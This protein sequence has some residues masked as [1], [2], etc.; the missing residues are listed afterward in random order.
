MAMVLLVSAG[1]TLRSFFGLL[2]VDS[3]FDPR[4]LV[5]MEVSVAGTSEA[6]PSKRPEFFRALLDRVRAI[7]GVEAASA[8]NHAP[9]VGDVWTFDFAV[10]S[11]GGRPLLRPDQRPNGVF[12]VVLPGYFQTMRIPLLKGRD[13]TD[14]DV[15]DAPHVVII[16]DFMARRHFPGDD[17]IGQRIAAGNLTTP[18][19]C[20]VVGVVRNAKR[21]NWSEPDAEE[22]YFPYLQ[23]RLY[24]ENPRSFATY[25]TLVARTSLNP[26]GLI[27]AADTLART[28]NHD[29]VVTNAITMERAIAGEFAAPRFYLLLLGVFAGVALVLAAVGIYGVISHTVARRTHEIGVRMALGAG[30]GAI[31]RLVVAHGMRLAIAGCALGLAGAIGVTRYLRALLFGVEPIDPVTFGLVAVMLGAVALIACY[32]PARRALA[33]DPTTAMR[34]E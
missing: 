11:V 7:P 14:R 13:V 22:M 9:L 26:A 34:C 28:M 21:S 24:L 32:V 5:S 29:V 31:L 6:A 1:L 20:T 2:A 12:R 25:L 4:N 18:D 33:V 17:P 16:N 27:A 15:L 30:R 3:G 23:T 8:I 10:F 19:W